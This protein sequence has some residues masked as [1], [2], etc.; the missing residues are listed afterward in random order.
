VGLRHGNTSLIGFV[1]EITFVVLTF[2]SMEI[3]G[4]SDEHRVM[5]GLD[6]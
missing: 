6:D 4:T 3:V 1:N 2:L 5:A